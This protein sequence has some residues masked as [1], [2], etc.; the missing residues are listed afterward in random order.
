MDE[1]KRM[2]LRLLLRPGA[3]E[4]RGKRELSSIMGIKEHELRQGIRE[5]IGQGVPVAS[6]SDCKKGGYFIAST[7][8]EAEGAIME[9]HSRMVK[10]QIR[11]K[12]FKIASRSIRTNPGQLSFL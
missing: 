5:L 9:L 7:L 6:S 10:L 4:A 3:E 11:I 12:E 1:C 2:D 8:E